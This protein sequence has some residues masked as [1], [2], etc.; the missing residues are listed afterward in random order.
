MMSD[1][2]Y[3]IKNFV[4]C[5]LTEILTWKNPGW[6]VR[7]EHTQLVPRSEVWHQVPPSE[8]LQIRFFLILVDLVEVEELRVHELGL[9]SNFDNA[10]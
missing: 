8:V 4:T 2:R 10:I 6:S 5:Y 9:A 7:N 1:V 3:E